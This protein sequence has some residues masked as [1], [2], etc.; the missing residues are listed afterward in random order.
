MAFLHPEWSYNSNIYEVNL[1]Q[2]TAEGNFAA[3]SL[4]L[5]RLKDMGIEILWF[6][7]ITPISMRGRKG[8]LGSYYAVK[9][10]T[11]INPEFGTLEDFEKL[12]N[13]A[14][15]FGFKV[16][17]DWVA[18]HTGNDHDWIE[19]HPDYYVRDENNETINPHGWSDVSQLD[20]KIEGTRFAMIS[21]M[22]FWITNC[23]ID[24]F[25]C[26]MAHLVPLDFWFRARTEIDPLKSD[27]FWLAE[28][29]DHSYHNAFDA[30]YTW[31]WM[32]ATEKFKKKE[33]PFYALLEQL[34]SYEAR[35]PQDAF[36]TWFTSNHDENSWNG[37]EYEK[38]GELAIPLAVFSCT[39]NGMPI[40]YNGQELPNYARLR[41]FD[42][43]VIQWN[44]DCALHDFYK[45]LLILR[46]N[47]AALNAGS[48]SSTVI[49]D[50]KGLDVF[51]FKRKFHDDEIL[52]FINFSGTEVSFSL[53]EEGAFYE[54][55]FNSDEKLNTNVATNMH[56][57]GWQY[58]VFEK[59]F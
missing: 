17:I 37:T 22:K 47:H 39:W 13:K 54:N 50:V 53:N 35:F 31:E 44:A 20:F 5:P 40:I 2:Y 59:I 4:Q 21:A 26:D 11:A 30:T 28:C 3:F 12:V 9:N 38:Y 6:M 49:I 18:N 36:R 46:K 10:Y 52:V 16:I 33:I 23:D 8:T 43:D 15:Q 45:Q 7:P 24:G 57:A 56:L 58:K 29:D 51:A 27:L 1:R 48:R 32:H 19:E 42:K 34:K 14:H 41:F 25:R 55:L